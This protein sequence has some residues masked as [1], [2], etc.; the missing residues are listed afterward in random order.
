M[1][2]K[3]VKLLRILARNKK[4][5]KKLK[6]TFRNS[7]NKDIAK[8]IV[9]QKPGS[10]YVANTQVTKIRIEKALNKYHLTINK[11]A[12]LAMKKYGN[13]HPSVFESNSLLVSRG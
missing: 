11:I 4:D 6:K 8:L 7:L 3:K 5:L 10:M 2:N 13:V 12:K 9:V 1:N